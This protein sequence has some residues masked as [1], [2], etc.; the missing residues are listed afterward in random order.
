MCAI[1]NAGTFVL[2]SE[3]TKSEIKALAVGSF[4]QKA[5]ISARMPRALLSEGC[6][7]HGYPQIYYPTSCSKVNCHRSVQ[8]EGNALCFSVTSKGSPVLPDADHVLLG[9]QS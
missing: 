8:T 3:R 7:S 5:G 1:A 6:S 2:F 9:P 4:W